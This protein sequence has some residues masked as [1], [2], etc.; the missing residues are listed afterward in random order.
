MEFDA[1]TYSLEEIKAQLV[2]NN[3]QIQTSQTKLFET[4]ASY[5]VNEAMKNCDDLVY[6][7]CFE[8]RYKILKLKSLK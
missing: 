5:K 4:V 8:D 3:H 2:Y 6:V 7:E 1:K